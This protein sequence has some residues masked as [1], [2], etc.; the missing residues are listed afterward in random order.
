MCWIILPVLIQR[1]LL[2]FYSHI[3]LLQVT[4]SSSLW[5]QERLHSNC[6]VRPLIFSVVLLHTLD[7]LHAAIDT[8]IMPALNGSFVDLKVHDTLQLCQNCHKRLCRYLRSFTIF[9]F[10]A[11]K[12]PWLLNL[13][14][15]NTIIIMSATIFVVVNVT[16]FAAM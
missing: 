15:V 4:F 5:Q 2:F 13:V 9:K 8:E 6:F 1:V 3:L 11:I 7:S 14:K 10:F 12:W 16:T